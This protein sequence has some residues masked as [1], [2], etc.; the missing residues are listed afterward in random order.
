MDESHLDAWLAGLQ[1]NTPLTVNTRTYTR[2][3]VGPGGATRYL[4]SIDATQ[5]PTGV[6]FEYARTGRGEYLAE[7]YAL[8]VSRPEFLHTALPKA[9][10]VWLKRVVFHTSAT[11]E[12]WAV[13][14]AV[15]GDVPPALLGRLQRVFT[16]QQAQPIVDE[17]LRG[18]TLPAGDRPA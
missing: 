1:P 16:W 5:L 9:Q 18:Q 2:D 7:L 3:T 15:K 10:L 14:L 13:R 17:I 4:T 11:P 12:E 6:E 8:A